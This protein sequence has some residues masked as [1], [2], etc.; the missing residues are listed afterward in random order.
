MIYF[1]DDFDLNLNPPDPTK[2][3]SVPMFGWPLFTE[4][5]G[6]LEYHDL[7]LFNENGVM[8][9]GPLDGLF[10]LVGRSINFDFMFI[11]NSG[12]VA[13]LPGEGGIYILA[14]S[15]LPHISHFTGFFLNGALDVEPRTWYYMAD[16]N[17]G[18]WYYDFDVTPPDML[19][20]VNHHLRFDFCLD[21]NIRFYVDNILIKI[22]GAY[23]SGNQ[24]VFIFSSGSTSIDNFTIEDIPVQAMKV[25]LAS[26]MLGGL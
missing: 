15:D 14:T 11:D 24:A 22:A 1:F 5:N 16:S 8:A 23:P 12:E 6:R 25:N 20:G 21:G 3:T 4:K 17:W 19:V 9:I 7:E 2:W 18:E 10:D 26:M 13:E